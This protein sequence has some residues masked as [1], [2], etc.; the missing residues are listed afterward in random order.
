MQSD[1]HQMKKKSA[2]NYGGGFNDKN[3]G[4]FSHQIL[5]LFRHVLMSSLLFLCDPFTAGIDPNFKVLII[6]IWKV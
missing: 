3:L 1:A 5:S 4:Q 6:E 2:Q